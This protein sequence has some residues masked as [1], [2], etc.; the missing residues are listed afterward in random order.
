MITLDQH[1]NSMSEDEARDEAI[2]LLAEQL[3]ATAIKTAR[4]VV[5]AS[6]Y[7][8]SMMDVTK[9]IDSTEFSEV[10]YQMAEK[11]IDISEGK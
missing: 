1:L 6:T 5:V 4:D 8:L 9:A 7:D 2:E 11:M 3:I 10:Y